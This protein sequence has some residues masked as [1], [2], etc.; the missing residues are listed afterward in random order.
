M[1]PAIAER[2]SGRSLVPDPVF[3]R[4]VA[5]I[6]AD[7]QIERPLAE[8]IMDQALAFVKTCADNPGVPLSPSKLVDIGWHTFILHTCEYAAF[9]QHMAGRFIH[10]APTDGGLHNVGDPHATL[11]NTIN[12]LTLSGFAVDAELWGPRA[13]VGKCTDDE[14]GKCHQCHAG[15]YDSP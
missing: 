15:C 9:C 14:G 8:R 12:A 11:G 6:V 10:H 4:L 1:T 13:S 7:E 3:A 5:R 2:V